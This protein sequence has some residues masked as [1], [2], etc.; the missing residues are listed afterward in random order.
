MQ[1]SIVATNCEPSQ[2][3][4]NPTVYFYKF[5]FIVVPNPS[6]SFWLPFRVFLSKLLWQQPHAIT[7]PSSIRSS[8]LPHSS[9]SSLCSPIYV[10]TQ[11]TLTPHSIFSPPFFFTLRP[12]LQ[13]VLGP[14]AKFDCNYF[15]ITHQS[16]TPPLSLSN[17]SLCSLLKNR[18]LHPITAVFSPSPYLY[19]LS[20]ISKQ[21]NGVSKKPIS[22]PASG[23]T[24][25]KDL[26]ASSP[27][28]SFP[29]GQDFQRGSPHPSLSFSVEACWSDIYA[30]T[31]EGS[32]TALILP[33][34]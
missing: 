20:P 22:A 4:H 21:L 18:A 1:K 24:F 19:L 8:V 25:N 17:C 26:E 16:N 27:A 6:Y 12:P 7:S 10:P 30:Q 14:S 11:T 33:T 31:M 2:A 29:P 9:P 13:L 15:S 5:H 34:H 23:T 3:F 28:S 32:V